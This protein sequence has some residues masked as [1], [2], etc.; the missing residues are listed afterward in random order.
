MSTLIALLDA[1]DTNNL[2]DVFKKG[3]LGSVMSGELAYIRHVMETVNVAAA[4]ATPTYPVTALLFVQTIATGAPAVKA[5]GILGATPGVGAAAPNA[6][7]TSIVFNAET[8]GTGTAVIAYLTTSP[9]AGAVA[10]TADMPGKVAGLCPTSRSPSGR[11]RRRLDRLPPRSS[12]R[13]FL[14]PSTSRRSRK[15]PRMKRCARSSKR[16][17]SRATRA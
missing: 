3:K 8:T 10:M 15:R 2:G 14:R 9:P 5:P 6:A 4:A 1:G 17:T 13:R 12:R 11:K 7:G 16:T